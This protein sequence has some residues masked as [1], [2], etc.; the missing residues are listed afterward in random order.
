LE[1]LMPVVIV[2]KWDEGIDVEKYWAATDAMGLREKLPEG[3]EY[4]M[5]GE[6]PDEGFV[7]SEVWTSPDVFNTFVETKLGPTSEKLGISPPSSVTV[8]PLIRHFGL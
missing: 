3:C 7:I 1:E 6:G 8:V 5:A 2:S 4:H